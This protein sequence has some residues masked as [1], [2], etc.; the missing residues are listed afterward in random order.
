MEW[1]GVGGDKFSLKIRPHMKY[2]IVAYEMRKKDCKK[3]N[4][5]QYHAGCKLHFRFVLVFKPVRCVLAGSL[6]N[7]MLVAK[8]AGH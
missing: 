5:V 2:H 7:W 3:G 6:E 1:E 4:F 8:A